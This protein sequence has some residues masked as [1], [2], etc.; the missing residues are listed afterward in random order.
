M[1]TIIAEQQ[2]HEEEML[3]ERIKRKITPATEDPF[4]II[5]LETLCERF[6]H[7]NANLSPIHPFYG[8]FFLL[9][10][11]PRKFQEKN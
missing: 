4:Y 5:D 7:W 2:R 11:F 3:V 9:L 6:N 8:L 10:F 1:T